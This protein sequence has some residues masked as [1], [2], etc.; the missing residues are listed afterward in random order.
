VS[1]HTHP[2]HAH[3]RIPHGHRLA[4]PAIA[5]A[6]ANRERGPLAAAL[7]SV[8][9]FLV[10]PANSVDHRGWAPD[11]AEELRARP[12]IAVFGLARGCG[13]TTV[14]RA[15]AAELAAR[16]PAGVATVAGDSHGAGV[17]VAS[18]AAGRLARALDDYPHAETRAV[19]RLCLV[20]G[21][22]PVTLAEGARHLAPL[23]LDAGSS[24]VG[25]VPAS[26]ADHSLLVT[27]PAVEPALARVAAD[28]LA[29]VGPEPIIVLNRVTE[30]ATRASRDGPRPGVFSE[31]FAPDLPR[32]APDQPRAAES[33]PEAGWESCRYAGAVIALPASRL[34]AQLA[35]RGGEPRGDFGRAIARLADECER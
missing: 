24:A 35:Q 14:A 33:A 28:C 17:R 4:P 18:Q 25:G 3:A 29:R 23:V 1:G 16:D 15:L 2:R 11:P 9:G 7:A 20:S 12:V 22:D 10:E 19:G 31:Q 34:G 26:L 6:R 5:A 27:T 30:L 8:G 13:T 21:T 32:T